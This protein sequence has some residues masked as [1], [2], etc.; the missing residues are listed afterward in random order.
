MHFV[1]TL[2]IWLLLQLLILPVLLPIIVGL[3][4]T[5]VTAAGTKAL[6]LLALSVVTAFLTSLLAAYQS[7][8][9]NFDIGMSLLTMLVTFVIGVGVHY[10]LL[11]PT[12]TTE[13]LLTT[14]RTSG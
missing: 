2:N 5:K 4:S 8:A 3:V 10:G 13:T 1:S 12:G 6:T 14:G 9:E 7:G 11:K